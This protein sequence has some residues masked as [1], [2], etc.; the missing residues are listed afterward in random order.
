MSDHV[1]RAMWPDLRVTAKT[2]VRPCHGLHRL[3]FDHENLL[4]PETHPLTCFSVLSDLMCGW[5]EGQRYHFTT[6][7]EL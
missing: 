2:F 4:A 3:R 5:K 7:R 1:R 6:R